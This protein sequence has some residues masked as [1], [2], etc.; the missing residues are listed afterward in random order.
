MRVER[1]NPTTGDDA[2]VVVHKFEPVTITAPEESRG[3]RVYYFAPT[4][5]GAT[6]AETGERAEQLVQMWLEHID[7]ARPEVEGAGNLSDEGSFPG[8]GRRD[9]EG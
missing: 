4:K 8:R 3:Q 6:K 1:R 2:W 9:G 7:N 5:K